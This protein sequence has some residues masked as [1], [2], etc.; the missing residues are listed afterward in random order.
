MSDGYPRR[1]HLLTYLGRWVLAI[2]GISVILVGC[3]S[4][5]VGNDYDRAADFSGWICRSLGRYCATS[6]QTLSNT[7]NGGAYRFAAGEI[8]A[9]CMSK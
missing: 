3:T 2:A 1:K 9:S 7:Q 6:C 5:K 8:E 4:L